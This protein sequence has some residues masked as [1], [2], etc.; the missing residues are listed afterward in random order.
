MSILYMAGPTTVV[1]LRVA[2]LALE[3]IIVHGMITIFCFQSFMTSFTCRKLG[4]S[5]ALLHRL[6]ISMHLMTIMAT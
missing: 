1:I 6:A 5:I 3:I 4:I 2:D